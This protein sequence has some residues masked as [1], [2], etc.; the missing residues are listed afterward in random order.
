M[1]LMR[2][3]HQQSC[4]QGVVAYDRVLVVQDLF[5]RPLR[6]TGLSFA[7]DQITALAPCH[8]GKI[9]CAGINYRAHAND[10]HPLPQQPLLF[11]KPSTAAAAPESDVPYPAL[12]QRIDFEGELGVVIGRHTANVDA[13]LAEQAILGYCCANDVTARDIQEREN[14]YGTA[15]SF[16]GFA[17][18]GP[19]IE[20]DLD[21][22]DLWLETRVDGELRQRAHTSDLLF[23][24]HELIAY[25]SQVIPLEPGDLILTGTPQGMGEWQ[26]GERVEISISGIGTL[27]NQLG[28][29][30]SVAAT[31]PAM[32]LDTEVRYG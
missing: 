21:P 24:V 11:L 4:Y 29:P 19:C 27:G 9:I 22:A 8:P 14:N 25:I 2:F 18:F 31:A 12:S 3:Q 13:Y 1:K 17:P 16:P 28:L 7:L 5:S 30:G 23:P 10:G 15:K 32:T 6:Y 20:T 26:P